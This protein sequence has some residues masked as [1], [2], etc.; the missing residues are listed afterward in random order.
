MAAIK[1]ANQSSEKWTRRSSVAGP[2]YEAGVANPRTPWEGAAIAAA[3]NYRQGVTAAANAGRFEAGI[4][5]AGE[6]KWRQKALAKGPA[7]F[8]EGVQLARQDWEDGF[9]PYQEAISALRLP[10]RGPKGS[11]NNL[12]RVTAVAQALRQ[13]RER[14]T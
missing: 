13:V 8:A 2:D 3:N 14:R 1:P 10:P 5:G 4:R 11:P 12:Q 6:D 7:R 9:R